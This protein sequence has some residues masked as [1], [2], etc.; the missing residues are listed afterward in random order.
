VLQCLKCDNSVWAGLSRAEGC[1]A[2]ISA[3]PISNCL[4]YILQ[5]F[6]CV[7]RGL[8]RVTHAPPFVLGLIDILPRVC[9]SV[10]MP[11]ELALVSGVSGACVP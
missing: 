6:A 5:Q 4:L 7:W 10:R 2:V 1:T 11:A 9:A 8:N 3:A